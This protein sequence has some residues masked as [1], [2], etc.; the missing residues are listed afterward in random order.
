MKISIEKDKKQVN[1]KPKTKRQYS[2]IWM[3]IWQCF[4][5]IWLSIYFIV[6][7]V[8]YKAININNIIDRLVLT[9]IGTVIPYFIKSYLE[10]KAEKANEIY[11]NNKQQLEDAMNNLSNNNDD[12]SEVG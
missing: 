2:K 3:T 11:L 4:V 6:D 1:K 10:T 5:M 12:E 8:Y 9:I 7:I